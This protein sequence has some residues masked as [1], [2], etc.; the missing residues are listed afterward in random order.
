[1]SRPYAP[2]PLNFADQTTR[3]LLNVS[4]GNGVERGTLIMVTSTHGSNVDVFSTT[5]A[6]VERDADMRGASVRN[7]GILVD[8]SSTEVSNVALGSR[9]RSSLLRISDEELRSPAF[10]FALIRH[11]QGHTMGA[12]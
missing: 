3:L 1:V 2:E 11:M 6:L 10:E 5:A 7:V 12:R 9:G 4:E 8:Q